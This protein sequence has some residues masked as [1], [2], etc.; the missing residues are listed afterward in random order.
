VSKTRIGQISHRRPCIAELRAAHPCA[1]YGVLGSRRMDCIAA[2]EAESN[3]E[4]ANQAARRARRQDRI[5]Y[6][7][8]TFAIMLLSILLFRFIAR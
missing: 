3:R 2:W 1:E 6:A 5:V 4:I 7:T 8:F